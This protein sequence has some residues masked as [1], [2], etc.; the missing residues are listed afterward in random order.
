MTHQYEGKKRERYTRLEESQATAKALA[1]D[2]AAL[3]RQSV[4][5]KEKAAQARSKARALRAPPR[6]DTP[7]PEDASKTLW[8]IPEACIR[9][10]VAERTLRAVLADPPFQAR[11]IERTHKVGI[12]YKFIPLVPADLMADL[13]AHFAVKKRPAPRPG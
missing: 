6:P 2:A 11:L 7:P 9:L 12:Y 3:A 8:T 5:L 13:T 1:K 4:I 10:H